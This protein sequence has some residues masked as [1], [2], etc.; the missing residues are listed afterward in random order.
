M[1]PVL[2]FADVLLLPLR[3]YVYPRGLALAEGERSGEIS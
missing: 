3:R 2:Q 1:P